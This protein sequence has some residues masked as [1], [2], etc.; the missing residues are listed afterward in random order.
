MMAKRTLHSYCGRFVT[1]T[2]RL[3]HAV[4]APTTAPSCELPH[5]YSALFSVVRLQSIWGEFCK[6]III[7]SA[8]G[9]VST[10]NGN[11]L[12]VQFKRAKELDGI[13]QQISWHIPKYALK[14]ARKWQIK[15]YNQVSLGLSSAPMNEVN[16]LR[17]YLVHPGKNSSEKLKSSTP[18]F[19]IEFGNDPHSYLSD[20]LPGG[21]TRFETWVEKMNISALE[22]IR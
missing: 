10:L 19:R 6:R 3:V 7:E 1:Q 15:N 18:I 8:L 14:Q 12:P 20:L 17:N 4:C 9:N 5:I 13:D 21:L 16:V 2:H 11:L 22:A